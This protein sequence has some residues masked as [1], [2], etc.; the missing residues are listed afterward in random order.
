MHWWV[1]Q[2]MY[3]SP[4]RVGCSWQD[5]ENNWHFDIFA[6]ADA[7]PGT[8][9]SMLT[10]HLYKRAGLI[11]HFK[12]DELKLCNFLQKIESGYKADN[13]YHNR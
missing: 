8:T 11:R 13:P 9:L 7:T 3:D 1:C 5:A 12:L 6:F 2:A 10:F 4:D